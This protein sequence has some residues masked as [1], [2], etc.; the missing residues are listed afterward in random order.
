MKSIGNFDY[1]KDKRFT[2]QE[3]RD[4]LDGYENE[5]ATHL[6]LHE[7]NDDDL[8]VET[9][10]EVKEQEKNIP[11]TYATI[12]RKIGWSEFAE[13]IGGNVYAVNEFDS[14]SIWFQEKTN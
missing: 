10:K 9:F 11:V 4:L 5:G 3:F 14:V 1:G 2:I 12:R 13:V 6:E 7:D 8:T